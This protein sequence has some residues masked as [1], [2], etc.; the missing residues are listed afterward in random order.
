MCHGGSKERVITLEGFKEVLSC[1]TGP[2]NMRGDK[3]KM[4]F[5]WRKH[6]QNG[7]KIVSPDQLFR[8]GKYV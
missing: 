8:Y 1:N 2:K 7:N 5:R 6:H 4:H 3:S